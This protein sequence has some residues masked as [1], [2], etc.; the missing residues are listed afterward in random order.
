MSNAEFTKII[1]FEKRDLLRP[2]GYGKRG[3]IFEKETSELVYLI[4]LQKSLGSTQQEI[5]VTVNLAIWVKSLAS[6]RADKPEKSNVW[7]AH[8]RERIGFLS[9]ENKDKWWRVK[10]EDE[11]QRVS[12]EICEKVQKYGIPEF[13]KIQSVS[14]LVKLWREGFGRGLTDVEVKNYLKKLKATLKE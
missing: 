6:I 4:G 13:D 14:D 9:P 7:D 2:L 8:W 10:T 1:L 5:K 12:K 3:Q 11:A